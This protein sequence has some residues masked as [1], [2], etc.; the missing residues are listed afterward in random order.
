MLS[1]KG[2]GQ[3]VISEWDSG[4]ARIDSFQWQAGILRKRHH[5]VIQPQD[6]HKEDIYIYI[7]MRK[8]YNIVI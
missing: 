7:Y 4:V 1:L 5:I 6:T 2:V 8:I 3:K